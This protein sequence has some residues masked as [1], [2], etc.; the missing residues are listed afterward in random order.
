MILRCKL[1]LRAYNGQPSNGLERGSGEWSF[2]TKK[3]ESHATNSIGI[4]SVG[5][6]GAVAA[7]L[8][9]SRPPPLPEG[10]LLHVV[11]HKLVRNVVLDGGPSAG[12]TGSAR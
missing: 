4:G 5:V 9:G 1:T 10:P 6:D 3:E 12:S 7:G 2:A 11:L 8:G